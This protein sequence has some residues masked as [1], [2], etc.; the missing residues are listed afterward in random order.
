MNE[1]R[2][3][4]RYVKLINMERFFFSGPTVI[5]SFFFFVQSFA[6][7]MRMLSYV[8]LYVISVSIKKDEYKGKKITTA[9]ES[10]FE[11]PT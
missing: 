1:K 8:I 4:F 10:Q 5:T 7:P 6:F 3:L 11:I 2:R 9:A